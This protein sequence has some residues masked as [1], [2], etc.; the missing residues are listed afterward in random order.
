MIGWTVLLL[1]ADR[2]PVERKGVLVITV[3]P[4][5]IGLLIRSGVGA[6]TGVFVSPTAV[7]AI[8]VPILVIALLTYSLVVAR[9]AG[10]STLPA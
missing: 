3:F 8:A 4:V 7:A 2:K 6:A 1:W 5:V 9:G 10:R